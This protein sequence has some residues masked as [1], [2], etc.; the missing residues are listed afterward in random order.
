MPG[1]LLV[2]PRNGA[3]QEVARQS[4]PLPL[5]LLAASSHLEPDFQITLVDQRIHRDWKK[6]IRQA[7]DSGVLAMGVGVMLGRQIEYGLQVSR[8]VKSV[9]DVPV[10]W[11]GT[12]AS[13]LPEQTVDNPFVDIVVKGEGERTFRELLVA[14]RDGSSLHEVPGLCF[15]DGGK[16]QLN[17][18]RQFLSPEDYR[19]LPYHILDMARYNSS[20]SEPMTAGEMKLQMETSRGCTANCS[21]CYNPAYSKRTWRPLSAEAV[22]DRIQELVDIHG[23]NT[24]DFVDDAYFH[25]RD[26]AVAI[27]RG[28]LK[29]SLKIRWFVQGARL[30][31]VMKIS[32]EDLR[33][34]SDAGCRVIRFG[35]ESG[36]VTV[37]KSLNKPITPDLVLEVNTRLKNTRI[38]PWYYFTCGAPGETR[39]DLEASAKL[40]FRL[41]AENHLARVVA[42][43]CV[44]PMAG[45]ALYHKY[46]DRADMPRKLQDWAEVETRLYMPW[47]NRKQKRLAMAMFVTSLFIDKKADSIANSWVV[48]IFSAMYRP[49]ARFRMKRLFFCCMPE[50]WLSKLVFG[51]RR[52]GRKEGAR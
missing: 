30:G 39:E 51:V 13:L 47:A 37:L 7:L 3:F 41:M 9:S 31:S 36:S 15:R 22:L 19:P 46:R 4:R 8:F 6:R 38:S 5:G 44:V 2:Y 17:R 40:L 35:V 16:I 10:V 34:H 14:L 24:I 20:A 29:R 21:F 52:W 43:F 11:G 25:D 23:A 12:H 18:D 50:L 32:D 27:S 1:V 42:T 48:K 33:L 45:S 49:I 26:R 28:I